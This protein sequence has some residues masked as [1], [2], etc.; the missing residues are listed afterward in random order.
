MGSC[1]RR[2]GGNRVTGKRERRLKSLQGREGQKGSRN[3]YAAR[4]P[5]F[6]PPF[7][8]LG[9]GHIESFFLKE[10]RCPTQKQSS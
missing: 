2:G 4:C 1:A 9:E 10:K 3:S 8:F 7:S 5:F 6:L